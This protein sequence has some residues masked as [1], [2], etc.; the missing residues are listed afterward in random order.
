MQ[1]TKLITHVMKPMTNAKDTPNLSLMLRVRKTLAISPIYGRMRVS[2]AS[3]PIQ[4]EDRLA[5]I[6]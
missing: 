2:P 3:L 6:M 5:C 4:L 1:A